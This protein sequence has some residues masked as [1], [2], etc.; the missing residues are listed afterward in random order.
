MF[1][2]FFFQNTFGPVQARFVFSIGWLVLP[3]AISSC[4]EVSGGKRNDPF[5]MLIKSRVSVHN[6]R[7][8]IAS[9]F[10]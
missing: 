4:A 9:N 2:P 5:I 7:F 8:G 6:Y 10:R 3:E 1:P